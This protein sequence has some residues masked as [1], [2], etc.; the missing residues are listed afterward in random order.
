[1]AT[2]NVLPSDPVEPISPPDSPP[3]T[4]LPHP[5]TGGK[6]LASYERPRY[7]S[8]RKKYRKIRA[9]FDA[10]YEE[11]R[12]LFKEETRLNDVAKRL[13]EEVD[14][15]LELCLDLNNSSSLPPDL[16]FDIRLR[17][18]PSRVSTEPAYINPNISPE[19]ANQRVH[20][21][22]AAFH[23]GKVSQAEWNQVKGQIDEA[24][25]LQGVEPLG[26]LEQ[27]T[28]RPK[29]TNDRVDE[30]LGFMS[31]EQEDV[32]IERTWE[33][34]QHL[35][36]ATRLS[37]GSATEVDKHTAELTPREL[38][39]K[40]EFE[41]PMSQHNWLKARAKPGADDG[42]AESIASHDPTAPPKASNKRKSGAKGSLMRQ[43]GDKAVDRAREGSAAS[44]GEEDELAGAAP[45]LGD[46]G[47]SVGKKRSKDPD[48]TYRV[49]GGKSGNAKGKRKRGGE[50]EGG[51]GSAGG[52]KARLEGGGMAAGED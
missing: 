38:E 44:F 22:T 33:K 35:A 46:V 6:S 4:T 49:K 18:S 36:P 13:K 3:P 52:K 9:V 15:L 31:F 45:G 34:Y 21:Y 24:L 10:A 48:S 32:I 11:N 29:G 23:T 39:R 28:S 7:K 8:W 20:D 16:R 12:E 42:D 30:E 40:T 27:G 17:D 14:G 19:E 1:M 5:T 37:R 41:N 25:A 50:D 51:A 2:S 43:M 26:R 47:A